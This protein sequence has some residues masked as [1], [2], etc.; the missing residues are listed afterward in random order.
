MISVAQQIMEARLSAGLTRT[1]LGKKAGLPRQTILRIEQGE[2]SPTLQTLGKI[3]AALG[4]V[5]VVS[6]TD[7]Q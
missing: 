2:V 7:K 3:A 5:L 4:T 1:Q 6:R